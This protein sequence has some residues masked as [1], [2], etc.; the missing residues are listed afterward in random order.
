MYKEKEDYY[1]WK[2]N[3]IKRYEF[4]IH[5]EVDKEVYEYFEQITNKRQYLIGLI[6]EDMNK[7]K[8]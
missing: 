6:K 3:F 7:K 4:N 2:K 1:K 5:K 8:R